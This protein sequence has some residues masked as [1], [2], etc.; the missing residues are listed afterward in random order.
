MTSISQSGIS[1]DL[2]TGWEAKFRRSGNDPDVVSAQET[3]PGDQYSVV[4]LSNFSLPAD[5][6]DYGSGAV[7]I[8]RSPDVL[9]VLTE[10]GPSSVG[11]AMFAAHG[12]P[13]LTPADFD[14]NRLQRVLVG[15]A[16]AQKFFTIG[17]RAFGLYVVLGS[18]TRR[19]RTAAM[20]NQLIRGI[21]IK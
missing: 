16:G 11:T 17:G 15:Q 5:S 20:I 3:H 8:M 6:G 9:V 1:I 14:P 19:F 21:K 10:F 13:S 4:H 18:Y 7:E 2:L 12:L